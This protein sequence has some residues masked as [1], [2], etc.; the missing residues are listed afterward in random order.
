MHVYTRASVL[1]AHACIPLFSVFN[2]SG[3]RVSDILSALR[4]QTGLD[5]DVV[6]LDV[7]DD[8]SKV[9]LKEVG[10]PMLSMW[11]SYYKAAKR[12]IVGHQRRDGD[13]A[14]ACV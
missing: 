10:A 1:A 12:V 3:A 14:C 2:V 7:H 13:C 9:K 11:P 8:A 6:Q 5:L 4:L